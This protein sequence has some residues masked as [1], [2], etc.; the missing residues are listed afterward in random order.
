[1]TI[2]FLDL[3][4]SNLQLWHGGDRVQSPG[5]ALLEGREYRFGQTAR[6]AARLR[7]R[8]VNTRY[9]W[10]LGTEA[11][12]PPLGPARHSADLAHA[13]L[14]DIH[15]QAG[16]PREV[17]LAVPG[18]MARE[19]LALL[20][21]IIQ[22]CPF[23][24]VG[25]VHR[26]VALATLHG[27]PGGTFHLELQLHQAVVTELEQSDGQ[28][29]LRRTVPLPGCGLLQLQERLVEIVSAAFIRQTRFDPRRRAVTEQ[30]LY[31]ALPDALRTLGR[32]P[33]TNLEVDGYRAR[34]SRSELRAA[35]QGLLG[36]LREVLGGAPA[37]R[38]RIA[39]APAGLL[40]GLADDL[41]AMEVLPPETLCLALTHHRERLVQRGQAL[42]FITALPTLEGQVVPAR[43]PESRQR[44]A[45]ANSAA[46]THL[47]EGGR[48]VPLADGTALGEGWALCHS[49][50]GWQLR[51]GG[52]GLRL[53]GADYRPGQPLCAGDR[54]SLAA[55]R[56]LRL[57]E[58]VP[59]GG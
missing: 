14:L 18:S 36:T 51:G 56:E 7:P 24:A 33:E 30:R 52:G 31:D 3:L 21:G 50:Q 47:L 15:R 17:M 39:D 55:G 2:A 35:G 46:P 27:G 5:Y 4:D 11:L 41:P 29:A 49:G 40:P 1:M 43:R 59:R 57:I 37:E 54:I 20:L 26:S 32:E 34:V 9:W 19:Q 6:A 10:Q 38:H 25:L 42:N 44:P 53:N 12:Q 28:V 16:G 58:V 45:P 22:Q 13:H 23:D 48:A 8:D